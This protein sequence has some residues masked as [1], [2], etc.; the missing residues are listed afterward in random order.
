MN[1][2]PNEILVRE[3][4]PLAP[5]QGGIKPGGDGAFAPRGH[6]LFV[7]FKRRRLILT[8]FVVIVSA[9][10]LGSF[11][12]A[13]VYEAA[14]KIV[15][16]RNLEAEKAM[17]FNMNPLSAFENFDWIDT[18]IE[19]IKS[20]PIAER[21]VTAFR[22]EE[23]GQ[24]E[25][26]KNAAEKQLRF[27]RAVELFMKTLSVERVKSSNVIT[28]GYEA[29]DSALVA[30][31]VAKVID[32]Y[33][34]YRSEVYNEARA[35]SFFDEQTRLADEQLRQLEQKQADFKQKGAVLSPEA[36][37][38]ILLNRLSDYEKSLTSVRTKRLSKEARFAVIQEQ[39]AQGEDVNIPATE[40]S[41]SPSREKHI[42]KLKG[43]W[44]D[45]E[46]LKQK[47]LQKFTPQYEEVVELEQQ[48]AAT[49]GK[50]TNE[51]KQIL[52]EEA[53]VI[54]ALK[55]EE[56]VLQSSIA[57]VTQEISQF[58]QK[59]YQFSQFSRGLNDRRDVYSMLLRQREEARISLAKSEKGV[60]IKVFSPAVVPG[61]PAKPRKA[62]NVALAAILGILAGVSLALF[63]EY[64][65]RSINS[66]S[67]LE[68]LSGLALL[69][70]VRAVNMRS[71]MEGVR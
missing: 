36:Q 11:L 70:A 62:L 50:I 20:R 67:E 56:A 49:R 34:A 19:M 9:V 24:D 29:K 60:Q 63:V 38:A 45:M 40:T 69:G 54:R 25:P 51:I 18:E 47:L 22:L 21:V 55:A 8:V 3:N 43:E 37:S 42:A 71:L 17:L 16:E 5:L 7:L 33:S 30:A 28:I 2:N 31:V 14:A 44:L 35:L 27:E 39:F 10:A 41:D 26:A 57:Q 48:I 15:V 58:A 1:H 13:P 4:T 32:T 61:K 64:F 23:L 53:T 59:E 66:A 6:A 52:A 46:L 12:V 68:Q 65:D